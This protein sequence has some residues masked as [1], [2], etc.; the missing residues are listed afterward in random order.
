MSKIDKSQLIAHAITQLERELAKTTLAAQQARDA[1]TN[2]QSKAETQYDTLSIEA[3]Y[4]AEGHS[5]RIAQMKKDIQL[6]QACLTDIEQLDAE[7]VMLG[8]LVQL[9]QDSSAN[10]WFFISPSA[11][12]HKVTNENYDVTFVTKQ[13]PMAQALLGKMVDDEV[14]LPLGAF[15]ISDSI[16]DIL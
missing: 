12:G 8:S 9:E 2:E 1:A 7:E 4:L 15:T 16:V 10:H 5:K 14:S 13:S 6:L 11:G 3:G